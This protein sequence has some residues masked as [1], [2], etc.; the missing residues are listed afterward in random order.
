MPQQKVQVENKNN[1]WLKDTKIVSRVI[2]NNFRTTQRNQEKNN[3][4]VYENSK[5]I[6]LALQLKAKIKAL[7]SSACSKRQGIKQIRYSIVFCVF[8]IFVGILR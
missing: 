1:P 3:Y 8:T 5:E 7:P 2:G 4:I 6:E